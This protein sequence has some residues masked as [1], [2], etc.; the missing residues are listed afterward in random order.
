[1]IG[2]QLA[3]GCAGGLGWIADTTFHFLARLRAWLAPL[4]SSREAVI[5]KQM[6]VSNFSRVSQIGS[7]I[8]Y[9]S[10]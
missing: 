2:T 6:S 7:N 5:A 9:V 8:L 10:A 1:M 4:T 3:R